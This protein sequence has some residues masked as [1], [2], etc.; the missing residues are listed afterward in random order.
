MQP[1]GFTLVELMVALTLI[2]IVLHLAMPSFTSRI[3]GQRRQVAANEL[4]SGL[5]SARNEAILRHQVILVTPIDGDWS[6]GWTMLMDVNGDGAADENNPV[7]AVRSSSGRVRVVGN[8][9]VREQ[10]RFNSLGELIASGGGFVAGSLS[11]C[12]SREPVTR[13][14]VV[15]ART[16]RIRLAD[17]P[18]EQ[19]SCASDQGAD[20]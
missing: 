12:D 14:R 20:A 5:R 16:G 6:L 8:N 3:E 7:L 17:D 1:R 13:L 18:A 10:V 4:V 19:D 2:G 15:I 11:L 9:R